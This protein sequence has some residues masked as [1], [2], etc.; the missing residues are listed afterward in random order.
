MSA[1]VAALVIQRYP[2]EVACE[3]EL[4]GAPGSTGAGRLQEELASARAGEASMIVVDL[5]GVTAIGSLLGVLRRAAD[6]CRHD[7]IR[8]RLLLSGRPG[9]EPPERALARFGPGDIALRGQLGGALTS[10][11]VHLNRISAAAQ[12]RSAARGSGVSAITPLNKL[13]PA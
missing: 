3:I 4:R 9:P 8:L 1:H 10:E 11:V 7:A 2:H 5:R 6:D 13:P 12:P